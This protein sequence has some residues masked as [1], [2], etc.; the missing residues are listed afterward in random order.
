MFE[1]PYNE[2]YEER[3]Q[4][5]LEHGIGLWDVIDVCYRKGSLDSNIREE[6]DNDFQKL[7]SENP[8]IKHVFFNGAKAYDTFRKRVGFEF[9]G[10]EFVKLGSTSPARAIRFDKRIDDWK[11][12]V[13]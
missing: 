5:L 4:F 3:I 11:V 2:I 10:I 6:G 1:E 7:F 8:N 13:K 12:I 9:E